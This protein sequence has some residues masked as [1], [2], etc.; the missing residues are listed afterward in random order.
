M[1]S[2]HLVDL[3]NQQSRLDLYTAC[4]RLRRE[5][6]I[7]SMGWNLYESF[8]CE[9]DQYDIPAS[10]HIAAVSGGE[11]VGCIRLLRTDSEHSSTTYMILD[12]HRGKIPNLPANIMD[13]ELIS[14]RAWEASRLAISPSVDPTNRNEVLIALVNAAR[15]YVLS[16]GG[17]TML[18][19]M[20]P[21]FLRVLRRGGF[22]VEKFGP[23]ANQRD[24]RICVLR[25]DFRNARQAFK[26]TA[27]PFSALH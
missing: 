2:T 11:L 9:F 24:G 25:W 20:N 26:V 23:V 8:G 22:D 18:G 6:F 7:S 17:T 12:A 16:Q 21:V 14:D 1:I 10:V 5:V 4:L 15:Q 3:T 13:E 27:E 19:L